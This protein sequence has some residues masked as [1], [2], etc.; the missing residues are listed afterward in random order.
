MNMSIMSVKT[1]SDEIH[2]LLLLDKNGACGYINGTV[3]YL[4]IHIAIPTY[5]APHQ[6]HCIQQIYRQ[7]YGL[8]TNTTFKPDVMLC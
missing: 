4:N 5:L 6:Q 8:R 1:S 2:I 7:L 3:R